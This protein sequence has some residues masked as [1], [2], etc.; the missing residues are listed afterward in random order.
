MSHATPQLIKE[1]RE[2]TGAPL[3]KCKEA[4]E[5]SQGKVELSIEYLRKT[6]IASAVKKESR[7]TK[8]GSILAYETKE[9]VALVE[10]NAETDFV[11]NNEKF[12]AFQQE[13]VKEACESKVDSLEA[14]LAKKCKGDSSKT[15]DEG[16]KELIS[17]LGENINISRVLVVLKKPNT[18]IGVYSHMKGKILCLVEIAG[19]SGEE[20][21]AREVAMH[22]AAEAPDY[23][24]PE[25]V[26]LEVQEKEAEIARSAVASN[27]PAEVIN[28]IVEGKVKAFYDQVCLLQQK[29][30]KDNTMTV[31]NFV[32]E[33]GK[34]VNKPLQVVRFIRW[35]VG[36]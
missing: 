28:K 34:A 20:A 32:A 8:E 9:A 19:G 6:G 33:R 26:P 13:V 18:S 2:R 1:L 27:K 12:A 21:L 35:R 22:I 3:G 15:I 5:H 14:L 11:V 29:F 4:L 16:R 24:K 25:E 17:V 36:A 10:M 23:L 7:T 31:G 30:V